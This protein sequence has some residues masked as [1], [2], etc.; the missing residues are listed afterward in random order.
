MPRECLIA[1]RYHQGTLGAANIGSQQ[2][3]RNARNANDRHPNK[4][5][6]SRK[7][8]V[9]CAAGASAT[10]VEKGVELLSVLARHSN[11]SFSEGQWRAQPFVPCSKQATVAYRPFVVIRDRPLCSCSVERQGRHSGRIGRCKLGRTTEP[12]HSLIC[13]LFGDVLRGRLH[14]ALE[15]AQIG[16]MGAGLCGRSVRADL[17]AGH[18]RAT[19]WLAGRA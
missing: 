14:R 6:S 4:S 8:A 16:A 12:L 17:G 19:F 2:S 11:V 3:R 15:A 9:S 7:K 18:C 13:W 10:K 5:P 1:H